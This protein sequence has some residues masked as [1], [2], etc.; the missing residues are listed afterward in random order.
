MDK[1]IQK[2]MWNE[3]LKNW[4]FEIFKNVDFLKKIFFSGFGI[5][6]S[7]FL[8]FFWDFGALRTLPWRRRGRILSIYK[9]PGR[10]LQTSLILNMFS[11]FH[12]QNQATLRHQSAF[13][14]EFEMN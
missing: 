6:K 2:I 10:L 5:R 1:L 3:I 7:L 14:D 12:L 8:L 13:W 11:T 9:F 4:K